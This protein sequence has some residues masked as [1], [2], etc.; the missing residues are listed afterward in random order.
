MNEETKALMT[1]ASGCR[2]FLWFACVACNPCPHP[3]GPHTRGIMQSALNMWV[4]GRRSPGWLP[5]VG[6]RGSS[7]VDHIFP[8]CPA[9]GESKMRRAAGRVGSAV[10]DCTESAGSLTWPR[11]CLLL[12]TCFC[13][14][15]TFSL[16]TSLWRFSSSHTLG[17]Q[18]E[19]PPR[20]IEK[21]YTVQS[22]P[23]KP[24][25][26]PLP[27]RGIQLVMCSVVQ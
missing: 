9:S 22:I 7:G 18:R 5:A 12:W 27:L 3:H 11:S 1:H 23:A 21:A 25:W 2:S 4:V 13:P 19:P 15:H 10:Q 6:S 24:G 14:S 26:N 8:F 20:P 16:C 17:C